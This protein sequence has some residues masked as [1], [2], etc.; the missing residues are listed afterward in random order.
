MEQ[1]ARQ[2]LADDEF[3][4]VSNFLQTGNQDT[5]T[6]GFINYNTFS[7]LLSSYLNSMTG[8]KGNSTAISSQINSDFMLIIVIFE[9]VLLFVLLCFVVVAWKHYYPWIYE[10]LEQREANIGTISPNISPTMDQNARD[11]ATP[12][13]TPRKAA[14]EE[15]NRNSD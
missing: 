11:A 13:T 5:S 10:L 2:F 1:G 3:P 6:N 8:G 7:S 14:E 9:L 12:A 15:H 4:D